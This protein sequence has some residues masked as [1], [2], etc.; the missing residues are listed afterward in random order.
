MTLSQLVLSRVC[1]FLILPAAA[2]ALGHHQP[3]VCAT[4]FAYESYGYGLNSGYTGS[5]L[6]PKHLDKKCFALGRTD[7]Q[8]LAQ[9]NADS[10][11][12][13]DFCRS[14]YNDALQMG[15]QADVLELG[16][17]PE[18]SQDGYTFGQVRLSTGARDGNVAV[19]GQSCVD[20][21]KQGVQDGKTHEGNGSYSSNQD[22]ACYQQGLT[23]AGR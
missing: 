5:S 23:E 20:A 14:D 2:G 19:V 9:A 1:I 11:V 6:L 18:C 10:S 3:G 4:G 15:L 17:Y 21:Y 22:L 16:Q 12:D 13:K 8:A 7:G